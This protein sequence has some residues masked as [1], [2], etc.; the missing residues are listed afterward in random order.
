MLSLG[1]YSYYKSSS[2]MEEV[3]IDKLSAV[4]NIKGAAVQRYF[5]TIENQILTFSH[6]VM[7]QD[8][9]ESFSKNF[10]DYMSEQE[11]SVV[12]TIVFKKNLRSFYKNE[13]GKKYQDENPD[14]KVVPENL[15]NRLEDSEVAMQYQYI[16]NN[17]NPLGSK[18]ELT[19]AG[20]GSAYSKTHQ[21]YHPAVRE[22]LQKFGY[23]DIFLV[24]IETGHIVYSV[25]KELDFATSLLTGPY[26]DTN[27]AEAFRKARNIEDQESMVLV[28]YEQY[29]PSYEAPASFIAAPIWKGGKK[30][31]V[32]M[33]QM[34]IDR[35]NAIMGERSG[36]GETGETYLFG[37]DR[38]MRS[39]SF[40]DAENLSVMNSFKSKDSKGF[41]SGTIIDKTLDGDTGSQITVN[42]LG[43]KV[44]SSFSPIDILGLKWG[45]VAEV[46]TEEALS[47]VHE[48][49]NA[50]LLLFGVSAILVLVLALFL[51]SSLAKR[52]GTI[53]QKLLEGAEEV[54]NSSLSISDS[55]SEL[56]EAATEQ[57]ASL[58]E[59]VSSIDEISSMVERNAEAANNSTQVST[60]STEA[61]TRGKRTMETM[62]SSIEE[63]SESNSEIMVE[64]KKSN[65]EISKIVRVISEIGEKTKVINDIVFQ[66]KLL[67]F[68]ASVEAARA[69]EHGKGF[70]VVAEEVGNLAS[71]SG[72]AALEITEMLD[73]SIKQ[74]TEIVDAT[75]VT[76]DTLVIDGKNK[77]EKGTNTAK[78]C[79]VA[80]DEI[81]IN[82]SS[83]NDMVREVA[84]ASMEQSTGVNEITKAMQQLDRTTHKNTS[85][86]QQS[87]SMSKK[88]NSH[89]SELNEAVNELFEVV[90]GE[91]LGRPSNNIIYM[92]QKPEAEATLEE[93]AEGRSVASSQGLKVSGLDTVIPSSQDPRFEDL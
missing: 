39:D 73:K 29:T 50:T 31:G 6:D 54:R 87:S 13:F 63:I 83:V 10:K 62:M 89:A 72:K 74:V 18:E 33:F 36:M 80:L 41:I 19:D 76:I 1:F 81:L 53:A 3:A 7:I 92:P 5:K 25:F 66:T 42:Y 2:A 30:V 43:K 28:D 93:N 64:M 8:A 4:R 35:L 47:S 90:N 49:K 65:D 91:S 17:S 77:I 61:A 27:F 11:I 40:L 67:S 45:L 34:P 59:T 78:E 14:S 75:K 52:I 51:S 58:Q 88:L 15:L 85:V 55:S 12:D 16:S 57:A 69:G 70:A 23:Y 71:M 84:T 56:S 68:N 82:V 22:F 38:R 32:A 26:K 37:P 48:L 9:V 21:K 60:K 44:I 24:D 79:G 86:A 46:Q 20:D